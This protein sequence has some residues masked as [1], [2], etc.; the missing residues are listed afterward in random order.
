MTNPDPVKPAIASKTPPLQGEQPQK[1]G[2][3]KALL[4]GV[5]DYEEGEGKGYCKLPSCMNDIKKLG[6]ILKDPNVG[7]F[8]V[9]ILENP[10][11]K[12]L[13]L[14]IREFCKLSKP[15][16]MLLIYFS[17]HGVLTQDSDPSFYLLGRDIKD[18]DEAEFGIS[19]S[20]IDHWILGHFGKSTQKI[21]KTHIIILDCCNAAGLANGLQLRQLGDKGGDPYTWGGCG[22]AILVPSLS[23]DSTPVN[24][25]NGCSCYTELLINCLKDEAVDDDRDGFISV[26]ELNNLIKKRAEKNKWPLNPSLIPRGETAHK[27]HIAGSPKN[28]YRKKVSECA[29]NGKVPENKRLE[30]LDLRKI[31]NLSDDESQKIEDSVFKEWEDTHKNRERYRQEFYA[32]AKGCYPLKPEKKQELVDLAKNLNLSDSDTKEIRWSTDVAATLTKPEIREKESDSGYPTIIRW[33]D[34]KVMILVKFESEDQK[35]FYIDKYPVTI[36][37]YKVY[38]REWCKSFWIV[39]RQ[40]FWDN[41]SWHDDLWNIL[42]V[43]DVTLEDARKYAEKFSKKLPKFEQLHYAAFGNR[44]KVYP[45]G[46]EW[47][48]R[49]CNSSEFWNSGTKCITSV[50]EFIPQNELGLCDLIG[51]TKEIAIAND[52]KKGYLFGISFEDPHD[53]CIHSSTTPKASPYILPPT[54][55]LGFRCIVTLPEYQK[56]QK[57]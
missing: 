19:G 17:G 1:V 25:D 53:L 41:N 29:I 27:I 31:L 20:Q 35:S 12:E 28:K 5:S 39:N 38:Y 11:S 48:E 42:P 22:T 43:T 9:E 37:Q 46:D 24:G 21:S 49:R 2:E 10:T 3:R 7:D 32:K 34:G 26:E 51:N 13:G 55:S 16:D 44:G 8:K 30:L 6:E 45:W 4:I 56:K 36:T 47:K 18:K 23:T 15:E 50:M 54:N 57:N 52:D 40:S 14:G 33:L